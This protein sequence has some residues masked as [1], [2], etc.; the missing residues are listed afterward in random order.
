MRRVFIILFI[1]AVLALMFSF[2]FIKIGTDSSGSGTSQTEQK[3]KIQE[4]SN[5]Q[6]E[7]VDLPNRTDK[8]PKIPAEAAQ[9]ILAD[10][11][12]AKV[13]ESTE[14]LRTT[15]DRLEKICKKA[16]ETCDA[17]LA[18][19]YDNKQEHIAHDAKGT[20]NGDE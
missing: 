16:V 12:D 17:M 7:P 15:F 9:Q 11:S 19:K 10:I 18:A 5:P 2:V 3:S 14:D 13:E 6:Q 20:E 4:S 1:T 8:E